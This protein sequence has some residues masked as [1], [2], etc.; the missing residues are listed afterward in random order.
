MLIESITC[1]SIKKKRT[2]F[3]F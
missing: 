2:S 1:S 3:K